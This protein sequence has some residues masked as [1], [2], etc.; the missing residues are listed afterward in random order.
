MISIKINDI[1]LQVAENTTI[2]VAARTLNIKIP[3]LCHLSMHAAHERNNNASCRV[4]VVEVKGRRNLAPACST[5]C[6]EGMEIYTNTP[7]VIKARRTILELLLSD[8]AQECPSC[9]KNLKCQL[10]YLASKL[11]IREIAYRGSHSKEDRYIKSTAIMRNPAKCILCGSCVTVCNKVQTVGILGF[12]KRGF[13]TEVSPAFGDNFDATACTFCG[14]CVSVCP[15]GALVGTT[16]VSQVWKALHDPSK[17]VVV[18]VAPAVRVA[19]GEEFDFPLGTPVTGKMV[20]A[21]RQLGFDRVF[22]TNF[23]AD[24]TILEEAHE[25]LERLK[26]GENLPILT[27]CC[28]GWINFIEHQFPDLVNIPSSCKSPHEMFGALVK[29]YYAAKENLDVNDIVVVSVMPCIAK[30]FEAQRPELTNSGKPDVD[31]VITTRECA[32][33]IKEA[34]INFRELPDD[35]SFDDPL[36]ESTGAADIFGVTGG[37][38]EAALRTAQYWLTGQ[39]LEIEFAALRG[40]EGV[41]TAIVIV[42]GEPLRIGV[43]SGLANARAL[44]EKVKEGSEHFDAIEI[45]ACPGGCIDGGGQPIHKRKYSN[46]ILKARAAGLYS[47]DEA[48]SKRVSA[49]NEAVKKLYSEYIGEIGGPRAHEL[50][51]TNYFPKSKY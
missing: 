3:T 45:M 42:G 12:N 23:A 11:G 16:Q 24:V 35:S 47:I 41:K 2:L 43:A 32:L 50:L 37:V 1:P 36:G 6:T 33:M 38:I 39:N 20:A 27:S 13:E 28:P 30:K 17:H 7:R 25:L 26:S 18:Q 34:G 8:H 4:C 29:S 46:T 44:L 9:A 19:L 14:Q 22:D 31:Y 40:L 15:T 48:K 5:Y 51:H 49:Q 21:L 10:Q